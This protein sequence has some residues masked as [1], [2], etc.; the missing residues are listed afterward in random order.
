MGGF[1]GEEKQISILDG[2]N[3]KEFVA[4]FYPQCQGQN[5]TPRK[6]D[7]SRYVVGFQD[8]AFW[9]IPSEILVQSISTAHAENYHFTRCDGKCAYRESAHQSIK[10]HPANHVMCAWNHII[11]SGEKSKRNIMIPALNVL[12][13]PETTVQGDAEC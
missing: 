1:Q 11:C 6:S 9:K 2:R 10:K 13:L 4:I 8:S 12:I 3:V 7:F 5:S